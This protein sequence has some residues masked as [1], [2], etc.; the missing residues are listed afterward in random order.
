LPRTREG[1]RVIAS[2]DPH[3]GERERKYQTSGAWPDEATDPV[4]TAASRDPDRLALV[5]RAERFDYGS[6][7]RAI[8]EF[9]SVLLAK[10]VRVG[11]A[12]VLIA[13]NE[14][15]SVVAFHAVRRIGAVC[16]LVSDHAG[17]AETTLAIEGTKAR[18]AL[19]PSHLLGQL[20]DRHPA[21]EWLS[22]QEPMSK[23]AEPFR[24]DHSAPNS[25]G[26][27]V[28]TS[29][30]T[31][32]PKGVIH[33]TNTLRVAGT[34]YIDAAGLD[35]SDVFFLISPLSSITGVLQAL[36]M[37]PM[38]GAC[39]VLED[40]WDDTQTFDLL[41]AEQATFYGGPDVV[42]R[43][44]LDEAARRGVT[45]VPLRAVS[46]GGALLDKD[47]LRRAESTYGIFVMRAYGSSEAPFS[48]TTPHTAE[49][50]DRLELDGLP[51]SGVEVRIGSE[52]DES[53]C[54]VRGPHLFL[55][56]FDPADNEGAFESDWYRTGDIGVF[57]GDQLKIV[58]R[59]KEIVI[60]N[61]IKL[62]IHAIED[63]A[64]GLPFIDD[65][66][67]FGRPDQETGEHLVLAVRPT[68]GASLNLETVVNALLE[69]GVAK[70]HLPEELI[71]WD[72]PFPKTVTEKLNRAA[73]A[74][75]SKGRHRQL[76]SRLES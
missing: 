51:N 62:S 76:A 26:V 47:L 74:E 40:K 37:A 71:I 11:D 39:A 25:P 12:V 17:S 42:L 27:V 41:V 36:V 10:G 58:G 23:S 30:S 61:G 19:S 29:G 1:C 52:G 4:A 68:E 55:G 21:V 50:E 9:A 54:L 6:L 69:L 7:E 49:L 48:T 22:C 44:L 63:A 31:S 57:H 73:L 24:G 60:R 45:S 34:N 32:L 75:Q 72:E 53:E 3:F 56:Y 66:A 64:L 15:R 46:V 8:G 16:V 65:A 59:L 35:K 20:S 14:C 28:F 18:L 38:L 43:R 67:A 70:R 5:G 2:T 13:V 33:S